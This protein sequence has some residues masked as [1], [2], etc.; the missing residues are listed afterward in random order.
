MRRLIFLALFLLLLAAPI[1][2][3]RMARP[4]RT[5]TTKPLFE[6]ITYSRTVTEN[7]ARLVHVVEIDLTT[8][9]LEF[10]VTPPN[11]NGQF[12]GRST[13]DFLRE[14][15]LQ[16]AINGSFYGETRDDDILE[17]VGLVIANGRLAQPP[18]TN[19]PVLCLNGSNAQ[20]ADGNCPQD[21]EQALAGNVMLLQNGRPFDPRSRFPGRSNSFRPQPRTAVALDET[22]QTMWWVIVDGRQPNY[23]EGMTLAELSDF[24]VRLGAYDA[25]NLDG[26][27]SSTLVNDRWWGTQTLNSPVHLGI[28]TRQRPIPT[29]L[30]LYANPDN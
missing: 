23:S 3:V 7:P 12:H 22:S 11:E 25:L 10:L 27:G 4:N 8:P 26:G 21:T 2:W 24:L 1:A 29:H 16:L 9:G 28:P 15:G 20:F 19:W 17:P 13:T 18:R 30:G 5:E 14:F 6:G